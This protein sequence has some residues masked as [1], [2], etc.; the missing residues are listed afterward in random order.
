MPIGLQRTEPAH[1]LEV[2]DL[3]RAQHEPHGFGDMFFCAYSKYWQQFSTETKA[4]A[5]S[6][7][8]MHG[9]E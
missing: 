5:G 3:G 7:K 2:S 8:F 9:C 4:L 6:W 1:L